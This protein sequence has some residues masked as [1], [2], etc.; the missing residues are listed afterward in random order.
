VFRRD[1]WRI[2]MGRKKLV[3]CNIIFDDHQTLEEKV[4]NMFSPE[5][6]ITCFSEDNFEMYKQVINHENVQMIL[7][8][9]ELMSTISAFFNNNLKI[10]QTS[11]LSY[12]HRNTL[13][14]RIDKVLK[15]TGLNLRQFD[16]AVVFRNLLV[17]NDIINNYENEN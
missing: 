8:D 1:K 11:G 3:V 10:S 16:H 14:Y 13:V 6:L 17:I 9:S 4:L 12:M 7:K 2:K 15:L 5:N